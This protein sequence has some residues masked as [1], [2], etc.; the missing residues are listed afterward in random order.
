MKLNPY[1]RDLIQMTLVPTVSA[2]AAAKLLGVS[3]RTIRNWIHMGKLRALNVPGS[4]R[5][6]WDDVRTM[7]PDLP[8]DGEQDGV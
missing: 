2:S 7:L 8:K 4:Y 3:S 1:D 5:L 6:L